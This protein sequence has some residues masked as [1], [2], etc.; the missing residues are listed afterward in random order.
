MPTGLS[1]EPTYVGSEVCASCHEEAASDWEGSHHALAW[2]PATP[3]TILAD[4]DGTEFSL[5]GMTAR[6]SIDDDGVHRVEVS[7]LD[8]S[9]TD[10]PVHSVVGVEPLQQ[11]LLETEPGRLQSFDVV[12]DTE[13]S[14]WFHLYPDIDLP[15][16]DALH[17]SGPYK[18]WNARCAECHA[19]GYERNYNSETRSYASR[20]A[21]IGVGCEACHGP[22]SDHVGWAEAVSQTAPPQN[23]GFAVDFSDTEA[24]IEQCATCHSRREAHGNGNPTPG[25]PFDDNYNLALLR[26]GLYH[27]DGQTLD[28]VYVYGSFLQSKMYARGVGCLD[29]H[30]A[31]SATPVADGNAVCTQCHSLAANPDFPTLTA[32]NYDSASHHFHDPGTEAAECKSC[33]MVE[34]VYM[35]NDWRADHSF[36]IPRPDLAAQTASPDACTTCHADQGPGWAAAKIAQWYPDSTSRGPRFGTVLARGRSDAVIAGPELEALAVDLDQPGIVRATA[37]W[38]LENANSP[39]I[40]ERL[41]TLLSD[42][43]PLVRAAAVGLQ[44]TANPQDRVM[45]LIGLL[46][47]P[48]RNVRIAT[49]RE[50]LDAPIA[51]LPARY[52]TAK[53]LAM[54]EWRQ[55][56]GNRLDFP[57]VHL[58]IAGTAL[59]TR[60]F[61]A[62]TR[63]LRQVVDLDPQRVEAWSLL[64]RIGAALGDEEASIRATLDEALAANPDDPTLLALLG[65]LNGVQVP[66]PD[67]LPPKP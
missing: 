13:K 46:E 20:Q 37:V 16:S 50:L 47:D 24:A 1:A 63:A 29:C 56:L 58:Q 60:N 55:S 36:R 17:W 65:E 12:W 31:H 32:G 15:P 34:R 14:A 30:A 38:L 8:G 39:S 59:M 42:P 41:E 21:E 26:P 57:E 4:F 43:D 9:T 66:A 62:A 52:E 33:H 10:Y 35:G 23:Y 5:R 3:D 2:S 6:F 19:T 49:A 40:A 27:A 48:V 25:E 28:E 67:L 7:E 45:R 53:D 11:Y 51:R 22:G 61:P 18:T 64:I 54:S 44:R